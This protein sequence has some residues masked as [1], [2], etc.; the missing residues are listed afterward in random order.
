[1]D[2]FVDENGL[3]KQLPRNEVATTE[4]RRACLAGKTVVPPPSDPELLN[5]I[6]GPAVLFERRVWF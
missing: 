4:Y 2:M 6:V 1:L 3:M 5:F